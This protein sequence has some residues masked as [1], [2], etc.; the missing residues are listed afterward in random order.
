MSKRVFCVVMVT[1]MAWAE[2]ADVRGRVVDASQGP[3]PGALVRLVPAGESFARFRSVTDHNGEF[4][5]KD[6]PSGSYAL[7]I[8]RQAFRERTHSTLELHSGELTHLGEIR[9]EL[10]GCD[11]PEVI[12]DSFGAPEP[13]DPVVSRGYIVLNPDSIVDLDSGTVLHHDEMKAVNADHRS[14]LMMSLV[15]GSWRIT[16]VNGALLSQT[17][18][19]SAKFTNVPILLDGLGPGAEFCVQ[20]NRHRYSHIFTIDEIQP[21]TS[22]VRLWHVTRK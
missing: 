21:E 5:I 18:C 6:V 3:L 17:D 20:T 14:D 15:A 7:R 2:S 9:L 19:R 8:G 11:A 10:A 13:N 16:P 12:C 4:D 22:S 1:G